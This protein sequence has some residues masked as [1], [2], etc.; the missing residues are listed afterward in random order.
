MCDHTSIEV[1]FEMLDG[2]Q[3]AGDLGSGSENVAAQLMAG[4]ACRLIN[5]THAKFV[6][7]FSLAPAAEGRL[8]SFFFV[9]VDMGKLSALTHSSDNDSEPDESGPEI[10]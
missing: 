6:F 7:R 5:L 4:A 8:M 2:L 9:R 3:P 1:S 10:A